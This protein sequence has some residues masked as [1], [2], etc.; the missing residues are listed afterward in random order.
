MSNNEKKIYAIIFWQN[1]A[2]IEEIKSFEKNIGP[3]NTMGYETNA[4]DQTWKMTTSDDITI[5][6]NIRNTIIFEGENAKK[7]AVAT[8][9]RLLLGINHDKRE[10]SYMLKI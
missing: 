4:I 2:Y 10:S 5:Y 6:V 3:A 8:F 9:E 7:R 1:R